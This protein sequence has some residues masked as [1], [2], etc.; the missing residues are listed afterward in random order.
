MKLLEKYGRK[1]IKLLEKYGSALSTCRILKHKQNFLL[2]N[3]IVF[4]KHTYYATYNEFKIFQ[5]LDASKFN[6]EMFIAK[7][8]KSKQN[9]VTSNFFLFGK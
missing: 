4:I 9:C 2:C 8:L 3:L 1:A 5:K 6:F 7:P